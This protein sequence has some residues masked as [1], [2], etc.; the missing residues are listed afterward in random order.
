[1]DGNHLKPAKK[2]NPN[3]D[4]HAISNVIIKNDLENRFVSEQRS[5]FMNARDVQK[6]F[7]PGFGSPNL[8]MASLDSNEFPAAGV[9][10]VLINE[11]PKEVSPKQYSGSGVYNPSGKKLDENPLGTSKKGAVYKLDIKNNIYS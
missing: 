4:V 5:Q 11:K 9:K 6:P 7:P 8:R 1:M 10:T 2:R 3:R